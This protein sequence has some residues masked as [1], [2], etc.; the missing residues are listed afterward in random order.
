MSW[1][2]T[3][4]HQMVRQGSPTGRESRGVFMRDMRI[5]HGRALALQMA[6]AARVTTAVKATAVL[7]RAMQA[8]VNM[9]VKSRSCSHHVRSAP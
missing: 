6:A 1:P 5:K 9:L 4:P 7:W 2:A 3:C 8:M